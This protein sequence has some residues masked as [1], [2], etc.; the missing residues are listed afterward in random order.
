M[1]NARVI[2]R[3]NARPIGTATGEKTTSS[4]GKTK[5]I[6]AIV[7]LLLLSALA[8]AFMP[9]RKDPHLAKIDELRAQMEGATDVQRRELWGQMREEFRNLP[10]ETR[11]QMF[12][13]RRQ[14]WEAREQKFMNDFFSKT[15]AEQIALLDEQIDEE[16]ERRQR[17]AQQGD[18]GD[19]RGGNAQGG[20]GR[21]NGGRGRGNRDSLER[22]KGYL[23][24][25]SPMSRAQR[26]EYRRMR[27]ERRKERGLPPRQ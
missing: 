7:V 26:S 12:D 15:P 6:I 10:E 25:T 17:R 16:Q 5:W 23:D 14:R 1:N 24:S 27:E 3:P 8:W 21:G 20:G 4:G 19:R 13:E 22:R 9:E 11:R 18:R 2:R